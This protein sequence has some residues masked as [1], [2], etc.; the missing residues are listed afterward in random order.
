MAADL[1]LE[2]PGVPAGSRVPL[3]SSRP[4]LPAVGSGLRRAR[5]PQSSPESRTPSSLPTPKA[6]R[7]ALLYSTSGGRKAWPV[8]QFLEVQLG[9]RPLF[10]H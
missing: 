5:V 4:R 3:A 10:P 7:G 9:L 6:G 2:S 8:A 1:V